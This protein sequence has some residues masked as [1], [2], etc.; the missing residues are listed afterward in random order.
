MPAITLEDVAFT[1]PGRGGRSVFQSYQATFT[2]GVHLL[3]GFSGCGKS[4]LLRLI[5][6]YL[7]PDAGRIQVPDARPP[8]D[9]D[10]FY[11]KLQHWLSVPRQ[12]PDAA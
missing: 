12:T 7:S 4:T 8:I 5:A 3:R 9:P 6:G 10:M 1:Y 11:A 2:P